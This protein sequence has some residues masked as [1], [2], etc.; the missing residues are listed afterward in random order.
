MLFGGAHPYVLTRYTAANAI[1]ATAQFQH[2]T[3]LLFRINQA[4][5]VIPGICH[6]FEFSPEKTS[7]VNQYLRSGTMKFSAYGNQIPP[8]PPATAASLELSL[9]DIGFIVDHVDSCKAR[10]VTKMTG[11]YELSLGRAVVEATG[12]RKDGNRAY[13]DFKWHFESLSKLGR[14]LPRV[15]ITKKMEQDNE[16]L[17]AEEKS[18]APFWTGSAELTKYDDGWR[19]VILTL[20]SGRF[21][22]EDW[23]YGPDW[24]DP[25]FNWNTFDENEN[26][27]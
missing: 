6:N 17:T 22:W 5:G 18:T 4:E 15:Q 24:P 13:V 14:S 7:M 12:I 3:K 25:D 1:E 27:Y 23:D 10:E 16:H 20:S 11:V 26:H 21:S 8:F 2:K 9:S 19:V